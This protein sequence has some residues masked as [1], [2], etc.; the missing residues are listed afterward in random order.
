MGKVSNHTLPLGILYSLAYYSRRDT[1]IDAVQKNKLAK[2][3]IRSVDVGW[4]SLI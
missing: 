1:L 2:Y 3:V 4:V